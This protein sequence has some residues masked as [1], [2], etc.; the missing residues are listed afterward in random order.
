MNQC[1]M[2]AMLGL[3]SFLSFPILHSPFTNSVLFECSD[4]FAV[5]FEDGFDGDDAVFFRV[6]AADAICAEDIVFKMSDAPC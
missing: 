2:L 3:C 6:H 5:F 1:Q 4:N